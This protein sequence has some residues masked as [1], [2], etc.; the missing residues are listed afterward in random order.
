MGLFSSKKINDE[1][2]L[3]QHAHISRM[4]HGG[5]LDFAL[6]RAL[7][8]YEYSRENGGRRDQRTLNAMNNLGYLYTKQEEYEKAEYY[9][10]AALEDS[11]DAFG[12]Y[13]KEFAVL[14]MNIGK[15]YMARASHIAARL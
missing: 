7:A 6:E 11:E 14:C 12:K 10:L 5:H 3:I 8:L 1:Y 4:A 2:W 15:M 9:L 13:S